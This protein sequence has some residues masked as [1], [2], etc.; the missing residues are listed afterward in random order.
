MNIETSSGNNFA[1]VSKMFAR[2]NVTVVAVVIVVVSTMA[3]CVRSQ[4]QFT[5]NEGPQINAPCVYP[6]T[7]NKITYKS[8]TSS[9][10]PDGK[11]W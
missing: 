7:F 4:C 6:F 3:V 8:C 10:D 1:E 2:R 9:M 11:F 5:N